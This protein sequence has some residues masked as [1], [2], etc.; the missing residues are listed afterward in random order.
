MQF[1]DFVITCT[2]PGGSRRQWR[3]RRGA[4]HQCCGAQVVLVLVLALVIVMFVTVLRLL[5]QSR[6]LAES[7]QLCAFTCWQGGVVQFSDVAVT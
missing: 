3:R 4:G 5:S 6:Q 1:S 2:G 7:G